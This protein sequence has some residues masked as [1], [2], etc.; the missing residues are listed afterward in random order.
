[1]P[2][3]WSS[4]AHQPLLRSLHRRGWRTRLAVEWE[5][6]HVAGA[7]NTGCGGFNYCYSFVEVRHL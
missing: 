6:I 4:L 2:Q 3:Q 5:A 1:M 7:T